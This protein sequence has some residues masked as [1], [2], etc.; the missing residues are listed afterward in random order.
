V[1]DP[2]FK[3]AA[4]QKV[5]ATEE[6]FKAQIRYSN[7]NE[8]G[9]AMAGNVPDYGMIL[10]YRSP[11]NPAKRLARGDRVVGV[12]DGAGGFDVVDLV[13]IENRPVGHLP[14]PLIFMAMCANNDDV[15]NSVLG[16]G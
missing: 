16:G 13:V 12:P 5:S 10:V 14:N 8:R 15:K 7:F 6:L 2:E 9:R 3:E 4:E 11:T 1:L